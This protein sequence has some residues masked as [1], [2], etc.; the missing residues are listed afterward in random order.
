MIFT[1]LFIAFSFIKHGNTLKRVRDELIHFEGK[2][3]AVAF[4]GLNS[5]VVYIMAVIVG[6]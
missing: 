1:T 4:I 5:S 6:K 3:T 2:I